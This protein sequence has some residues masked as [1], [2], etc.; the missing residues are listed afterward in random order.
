MSE[1]IVEKLEKIETRGRKKGSKNRP[2]SVL[3]EERQ[4]KQKKQIIDALKVTPVRNM[5]CKVAGV[6]CETY[7]RWRR[8]DEEFDAECASAMEE[9]KLSIEQ[10]VFEYGFRV[11]N[12]GDLQ[13]QDPGIAWKILERR[14]A[15]QYGRT[16]KVEHSG[17]MGAQINVTFLPAAEQAPDASTDC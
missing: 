16:Q 17:S 15:E 9:G 8:D 10:A 1:D 13:V 3:I 12:D 11:N 4:A 7:R 14:Y 6:S 5:V 2:K